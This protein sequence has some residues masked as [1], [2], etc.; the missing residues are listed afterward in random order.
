MDWLANTEIGLDSHNSV[1]KRLWCIGFDLRLKVHH[2][3]INNLGSLLNCAFVVR[4]GVNRFYIHDFSNNII[5]VAFIL[6]ILYIMFLQ[7]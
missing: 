6:K 5:F 4:I 2:R 7:C 1:I 3:G